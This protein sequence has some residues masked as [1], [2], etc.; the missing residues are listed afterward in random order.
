L[1]DIYIYDCLNAVILLVE[2]DFGTAI[3]FITCNL[4]CTATE[5]SWMFLVGHVTMLV[6]F[7]PLTCTT[8]DRVIT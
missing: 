3:S 1:D 7:P 5:H 2:Q 6:S 8:S 4:L